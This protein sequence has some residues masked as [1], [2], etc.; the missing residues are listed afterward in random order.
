[1]KGGGAFTLSPQEIVK[2]ADKDSEQ[3]S[4]IKVGAS[5]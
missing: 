4:L 2:R 3:V 5:S 1:M